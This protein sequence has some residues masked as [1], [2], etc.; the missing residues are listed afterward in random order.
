MAATFRVV[1]WSIPMLHTPDVVPE[2]TAVHRRPAL[3][4]VA[5]EPARSTARATTA[6]LIEREQERAALRAALDAALAGEGQTVLLAGEPGIGKTRLASALADEAAAR[7][8]PVWSGR[9]PEEGSAPAFWPWS[10]ALRRS[11][12]QTGEAAVLAAAGSFRAELAR[13]FPVLGEPAS[14]ATAAA[15]TADSE[16][17]RF[18]L[19][20]LVSR[21][22]ATVAEPRGLLVI[23]DDLQWADPASLEL[24]ELVA[25]DLR[26]ARLLVIGTYRDTEIR[27]ADPFASTLSRLVR[28]PTTRT[29]ALAGLSPADCGRWLASAGAREDAASLGAVLHRET[30]GNPFYLG[31]I[32]QLAASDGGDFAAVLD[33]RRVPHG[34]RA[35]IARRVARLGDGCRRVLEVAALLDEPIDTLLLSR[36]LGDE[37]DASAVA[38]HLERAVRDRILTRAGRRGEQYE[39]AHGLV[40]RLLADQMSVS[41]RAAWHARIAAELERHAGGHEG[42]TSALV[43]HYVAAGSADALRRAFDYACHGAEQASRGLAWEEAVRLGELALD[44]AARTG[45]ADAERV[46]ELELTLA[47]ALR[48]AGDVPAARARCERVLDACRRVPRPALLARAALLYVGP[49]PEFGRVLPRDRAVLEEACRHA[50]Q[51]DDGLQARLLARLAG[52][53]FAANETAHAARVFALCERAAT[54]ARRAGDQ[55][56]LAMALLGTRYA[57]TLGLAAPA[58]EASAPVKLPSSREIIAAA[59]AGGEHE[60][61]AAI[62]HLRAMGLLA[63]GDRARFVAE[64]AALETAAEATRSPDARWL[65]AALA[66]LHATV[67]GRFDEALAALD[68]ARAVGRRLHVANADGQHLTQRVMWHVARGR[69][70]EIAAEVAAYA[71]AHPE[72]AAWP[73]LHALARHASGDAAGARTALQGLLATGAGGDGGVMS[74]CALGALSFL[75]VALGDRASA[76][77]LYE[78]ALRQRDAWIVDGCSTLGP[79]D[80]ARGALALLLDRPEDAVRHLEQALALAHAMRARPFVAHAQALL[81]QALLATPATARDA[82]VAAALDEAERGASELGLAHVAALVARL[83]ADAAGRAS[84]SQ[85]SLRCE[86]DVW[87]VEFVGRALRVKHG[88]GMLYLATLLGAPGRDFHVLELASGQASTVQAHAADGL[89]ATAAPGGAID[90]APDAQATRAYRARVAELREELEDAEERCDNGRAERAR[91]ELDF[92]A[93]QLAQRFGRHVRTRGP[94]ETARKAVTKVLRTQIGKL[95]DAHPELGAHLRGALRLGTVCSYAPRTPTCWT[96]ETTPPPAR[97]TGCAGA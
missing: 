46:L 53:L 85:G 23:L 62:R 34:L 38:D 6:P 26:D 58:G 57:A 18:R 96:V 56:A 76:A 83:R 35:V 92:L 81:A 82:R 44:L 2:R 33:R 90:D 51:I 16:R 89:A 39:F 10:T 45:A 63:T 94:A 24:L 5:R 21:F 71:R 75:C 77:T 36:L 20:D 31:E 1:G 17:A 66:A 28:E 50:D 32:V 65:A 29:I 37:I 73:A 25:S 30:N 74:R 40:R 87:N 67:E 43:R 49:T 79:W 59:E 41:D 4:R 69:L 48:R 95:V 52:D 11:F 8:V 93:T 54:A 14:D 91:E 42:V 72:A 19:F 97:D 47:R 15:S 60:M 13:V 12:E 9:S 84:D 55:G 70:D 68:H 7:G 3:L 78:R 22:L 64:I 27:D 61:A 86:G 88:K 80:L